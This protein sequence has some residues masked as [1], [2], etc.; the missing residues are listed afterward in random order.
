MA[1]MEWDKTMS[2]GVEELDEQHRKLIDLINEAYEAIQTHDEHAMTSLIAKMRDYANL[3]FKTEEEYLKE[4]NYPDFQA[5]KFHHVKFNNDVDEFQR[6]Q[7][8]RTNLSQ[9]FV[10]LSRWL[11]SHIMNEDKKYSAYMPKPEDAEK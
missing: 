11:T 2:V 10:Y 5:H 7:F 3:H 4:Y 1:L 9:I 6:K 8:Q